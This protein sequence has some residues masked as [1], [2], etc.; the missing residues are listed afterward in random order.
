MSNDEQRLTELRAKDQL[1]D[2][3]MQ[4]L[5]RLSPAGTFLKLPRLQSMGVIDLAVMM[6]NLAE[7]G[8]RIRR[9]F[10][11][12]C[13]LEVISLR[14]Q[15]LDFWLRMYWVAEN[16]A[17]KIFSPT[18]KRTFGNMIEDCQRLGF[19]QALID[20]LRV[21]NQSRVD[22]IHKYLLGGADYSSLRQVCEDSGDLSQLMRDYVR[23]EVGIPI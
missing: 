23:G 5:I 9:A 3:E 20:R 10:E 11:N 21:F 6:K 7:G 1:T 17:G 18:D 12:E 14:V 4:E 15:Y 22:A 8:E 13:Y 16:P 2:A 19:D